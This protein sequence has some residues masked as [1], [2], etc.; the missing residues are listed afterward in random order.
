[1]SSRP[2]GGR[3][4]DTVLA[5]YFVTVWGS[6]FLATKIG[7]QHAAPFT[8][9]SLRF[10][11]GFACLIVVVLVTRPRWPSSRAELGHVVVAGLLM[12]TVHLGGSHYTQYLG[13]SAGVTALLLSVQPLLTAWIAARWLGERLAPRQWVGIVVGL[14]G[15][16]LVVWH[17]IDVREATLGSLVAVLV[18]LVGVTA[19][20]LYQRRYCP[21][22]DLRAASFIQFAVTLAVMPPL[23]WAI[24]G[25]HVRWS[26]SLVGAIVFLVIGASLL[27]VNALHTLMRRGEATRVT[28]LLYLTPIFAVV[29]EA[30][31]FHVVPSALTTLGIVVTCA[32]VALVVWR[33]PAPP[34]PN[35]QP[36][37]TGQH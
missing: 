15:V 26:W 14:A 32:G 12:H 11:F 17:K 20:T 21:L 30:L 5:W 7:L 8:F 36:V 16:A 1:M 27:A 13:M 25:G 18:S 37:A 31:M 9:L 6:G 33:H 4:F 3:A 28:S 2:S 24:E 19:A 23:A 22:V 29:L 35:E 10:A 34:V